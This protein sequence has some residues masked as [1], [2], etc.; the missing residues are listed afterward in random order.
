MCLLKTKNFILKVQKAIF[1]GR[2]GLFFGPPLIMAGATGGGTMIPRSYTTPLTI[3][4]ERLF[5]FEIIC[6]AHKFFWNE[7]VHSYL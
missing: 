6:V 2:R 3:K 7:N 4:V 1:L 5:V